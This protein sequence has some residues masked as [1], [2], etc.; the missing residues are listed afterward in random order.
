[1]P[2]GW[3]WRRGRWAIGSEQRVL[4]SVASWGLRSIRCVAGCSAP[5]STRARPRVTTDVSSRMAELER[6]N[7]ELKRAKAILRSASAFFASGARPPVEQM[8]A[9]IDEKRVQFEPVVA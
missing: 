8:I 7:R 5:R 1:M 2:S 3:C 6:E 9:F 4:V